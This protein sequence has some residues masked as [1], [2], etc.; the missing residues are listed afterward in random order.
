MELSR[1]SSRWMW[2][3]AVGRALSSRRRGIRAKKIDV[4]KASHLGFSPQMILL[5]LKVTYFPG[6]RM[7]KQKIEAG[8]FNYVYDCRL[9]SSGV[10][11]WRCERKKM[12]NAAVHV[13]GEY[14]IASTNNHTHDCDSII[15]KAAQM[16]QEVKDAAKS[17]KRRQEAIN[18]VQ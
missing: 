14:V 1:G 2:K 16:R 13:R 4:E 3:I 18:G 8:G 9:R 12:C 11:R 10:T 17:A 6:Q 5:Q 7:G 15:R